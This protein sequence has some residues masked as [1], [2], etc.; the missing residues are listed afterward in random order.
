MMTLNNFR[1][2]LR[3]LCSGC[4][5]I[6]TELLL[7]K[8]KKFR[9]VSS[10]SS[11][12][13]KAPKVTSRSRSLEFDCSSWASC[14]ECRT[15]SWA[16]TTCGDR[17]KKSWAGTTLFLWLPRNG[18][19]W[20][21]SSFIRV[22]NRTSMNDRGSSSTYSIASELIVFFL[23][24]LITLLLILR[25]VCVAFEIAIS[26]SSLPICLFDFSCTMNFLRS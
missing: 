2:R 22:Y 9:L 24:F 13:N 8:W 16:S 21:M 26:P 12:L 14:R 18:Y 10:T 3:R 20:K 19:D 7:T 25:I 4:R 11:T 15:S 5:L 23:S 6:E 1:A 17:V